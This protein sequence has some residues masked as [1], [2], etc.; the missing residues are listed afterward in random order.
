MT[1]ATADRWPSVLAV[2]VNW[3]GRDDLERCL[4]SL[5]AQDYPA[6]QLEMLVID[7]ASTDDS[8]EVC[9]AVCPLATWLDNP[10]N[11]GYAQAVNQGI[12]RGLENRARYLGVLNNDVV[13]PPDTRRRGSRPRRPCPTERGLA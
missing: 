7:N 4:A 3:N 11:V 1:T 8:R 6:Q 2:V 13:L 12:A 5:A 9:Q 10:T